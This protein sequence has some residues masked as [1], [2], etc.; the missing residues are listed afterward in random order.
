MDGRR[1]STFIPGIF[2]AS[3]CLKIENTLIDSNKQ[4]FFSLEFV[5]IFTSVG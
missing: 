1:P 3:K 4:V 2:Q 5:N